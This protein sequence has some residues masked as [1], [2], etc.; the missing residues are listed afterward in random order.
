MWV[1]EKRL[2]YPVRVSQRDLPMAKF[3]IAQYGGPD[4]ELAAS[5]RYLNQRYAMKN[6]MAV[7]ILTDIATEEFAH[8]EMIAT[9][10][11]KLIDGASG[12][13]MRAAGLG[14]HYADHGLDLFY[15]DGNGAPFSSTYFQAKGDPIT[16]LY[17]DI[18]AE[19]KAR[20]VYQ[21]LIDMTDDRDLQDGLIFLREREVVHSQRFREVLAVLRDEQA[22]RTFY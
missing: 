5:L 18:A 12:E 4:G 10:V 8:L 17:E 1:Y 19:E 7:A 14:G 20:A 11:H 2:Q 15:T 21:N 22:T 6:R 13:E 16:N 3:L 9:M